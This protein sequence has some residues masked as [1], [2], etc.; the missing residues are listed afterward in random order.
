MCLVAAGLNYTTGGGEAEK[1]GEEEA[2][3]KEEEGERREEEQGAVTW[4][5]GLGAPDG[6]IQ[7]RMRTGGKSARQWQ[8]ADWQVVEIRTTAAQEV[9]MAQEKSFIIHKILKPLLFCGFIYFSRTG[10]TI[11]FYTA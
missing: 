10:K 8:V 5:N 2:S 1:G 4:W 6:M 9:K 11:F 7:K 3:R